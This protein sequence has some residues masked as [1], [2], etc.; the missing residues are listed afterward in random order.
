M[1]G[2]ARAAVPWEPVVVV[3]VYGRIELAGA[4]LRSLHK[5]L[6]PHVT[7][8]IVDDVGD[9]PVPADVAGWALGTRATVVIRHEQNEGLVRTLNEMFGRFP[10]QDVIAVNSD[11]VALPGWWEGL[12][13]ALADGGPWTATA[14]AVAD[15]GGVISVPGIRRLAGD[16]IDAR[17]RAAL[18]QVP[19]S[20]RFPVAVGHCTVWRR[21]AIDDVGPLDE[22]FSPGY[23][24]EVDW[25]MRANRR[26]WHHVIAPQS[27]VVHAEGASFG[28]ERSRLRRRHERGLLR[29]YPLQFLGLRIRLRGPGGW[30]TALRRITTALDD[31]DATAPRE[32]P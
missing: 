14:T 18:R 32:L 5:T 26:G 1:T 22:W 12:R 24:E 9:A 27:L 6:P 13:D 7:V 17:T 23:G 28:T 20:A 3:A 25:S 2:S 16:G 21:T 8:A 29:R 19:V 11:V 15:R 31:F 4:C 30:R 10:Q